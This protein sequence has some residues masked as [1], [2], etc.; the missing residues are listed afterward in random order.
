M[1][2]TTR[3]SGEVTKL[4]IIP[5]PDDTFEGEGLTSEKFE[6]AANPNTY[7]VGYTVKQTEVD[8]VGTEGA[9][10]A[11]TGSASPDLNLDF[12]FDGTG[13]LNQN[14]S[15]NKL[16]NT[17]GDIAN[18]IKDKK[19]TKDGPETVVDQIKRFKKVVLDYDG[20]THKTPHVK[21]IWGTLLF[22][23]ILSDLSIDYKLFSSSGEP[24]RAVAQAKFTGSISDEYRAAKQNNSSPDLTHIRTVKA[25]DTLPLMTEKIY[26][27]SKYYL[28]V[29]KANNLINFRQLKPGMEIVFPPIEKT[30]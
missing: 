4:V 1:N 14:K 20:K 16:V 13:L 21:I 2:L 7:K 11:Y 17:V 10:T 6:V 30:S 15:G 3:K 24:L 28:E 8:P 19:F 29:A 27:D 9:T 23:G 26:G 12:I 18:K 22:K 5:Y 25:G